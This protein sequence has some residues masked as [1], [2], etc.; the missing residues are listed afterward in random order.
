MRRILSR[1]NIDIWDLGM[2]LDYKICLGEHNID[3]FLLVNTIKNLWVKDSNVHLKC[4]E[5]LNCKDILI[6]KT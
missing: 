5:Q 4:D 3:R 2:E 6:V 1:G